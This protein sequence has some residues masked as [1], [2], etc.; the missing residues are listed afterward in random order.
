MSAQSYEQMENPQQYFE[1]VSG[2]N[3]MTR[4]TPA[5]APYTSTAGYRDLGG[6]AP[7]MDPALLKRPARKQVWNTTSNKHATHKRTIN[8]LLLR[9]YGPLLVSHVQFKLAIP[10]HAILHSNSH[11]LSWDVCVL[12][13]QTH[14]I[15]PRNTT[16][17]APLTQN[18][19]KFNRLGE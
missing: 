6:S 8:A 1:E 10:A 17:M 14:T 15:E 12:D 19:T 11:R 2:T 3:P 9:N 4:A 5:Y 18:S 13:N 16:R 7:Y